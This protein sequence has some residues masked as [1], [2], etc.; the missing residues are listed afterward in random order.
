MSKGDE[1]L[2][3]NILCPICSYIPLLLIN[4]EYEN[5]NLSDVCELYSYCI[6]E[7]DNKRMKLKK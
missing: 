7:H 5:K 1:N 4:L 3:S 2:E 6:Y